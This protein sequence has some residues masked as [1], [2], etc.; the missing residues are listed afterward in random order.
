MRQQKLLLILAATIVSI[1]M[2]FL[3]PD[4]T[5]AQKSTEKPATVDT[6]MLNIIKSSIKDSLEVIKKD[7]KIDLKDI[8]KVEVKNDSLINK[9]LKEQ[10]KPKNEKDNKES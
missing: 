8:I 5:S 1:V 6:I 4:K 3:P 9:I 10:L 2:A 7:K